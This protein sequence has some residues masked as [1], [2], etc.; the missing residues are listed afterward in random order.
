MY[1]SFL[2]ASKSRGLVV[3]PYFSPIKI[4]A[5]S[6][7]TAVSQSEVVL[8]RV[9]CERRGVASSPGY[10]SELGWGDFSF[11]AKTL[12]E[13]PPS[14]AHCF[15]LVVCARTPIVSV[16]IF[17]SFSMNFINESRDPQNPPIYKSVLCYI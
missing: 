7:V 13:E 4:P 16:G 12:N 5:V 15:G 8:A 11:C 9:G 2:L 10:K 1:T 6:H 14:P 17:L 3:P